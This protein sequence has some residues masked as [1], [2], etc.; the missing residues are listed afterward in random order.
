MW[1]TAVIE[2]LP[3]AARAK[4]EDIWLSKNHSGLSTLIHLS[5]TNNPGHNKEEDSSG[6]EMEEA[7]ARR[8]NGTRHA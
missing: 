8:S 2:G 1:R 5:K 6:K 4:L 7:I 3:Q